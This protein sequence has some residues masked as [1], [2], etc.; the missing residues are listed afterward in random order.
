[1]VNSFRI[2]LFWVILV[3]ILYSRLHELTRSS[4]KNLNLSWETEELLFSQVTFH[5]DVQTKLL[6]IDLT[7]YVIRGFAANIEEESVSLLCWFDFSSLLLFLYFLMTSSSI[8][9]CWQCHMPVITQDHM[10]KTKDNTRTR[11]HVFC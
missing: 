6:Y 7:I 10:W 3:R 8:I 4:C 2:S 1:M 11:E 5:D 9:G